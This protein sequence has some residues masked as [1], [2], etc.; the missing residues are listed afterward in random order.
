[1]SFPIEQFDFTQI[2]DDDTE[3][4]YMQRA[5]E[6]FRPILEDLIKEGKVSSYRVRE[7]PH[8]LYVNKEENDA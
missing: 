6:R 4:D 8:R 3:I 2:F 5:W 7:I 1:M